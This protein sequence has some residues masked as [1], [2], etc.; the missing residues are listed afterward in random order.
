MFEPWLKLFDSVLAEELS[1][2]QAA[3]WSALAHRI[4][5]SLRAGVVDRD[6]LPGGIPKLR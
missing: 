3:R 5:R 1:A 4:G 6:I 2:A